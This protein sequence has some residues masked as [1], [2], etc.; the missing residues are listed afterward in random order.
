[1]T[2]QIEISLIQFNPKTGE[3]E[4]RY[5]EYLDGARVLSRAKISLKER[6]HDE[7]RYLMRRLAHQSYKDMKEILSTRNT[8]KE[9]NGHD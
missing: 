5:Y 6:V 3:M 2:A 1:M 9:E 7:L 4:I 8:N